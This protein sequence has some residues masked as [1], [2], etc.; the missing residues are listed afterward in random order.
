M[1]TRTGSVML[2]FCVTM[3]LCPSLA[4]ESVIK[5][6]KKLQPS[7]PPLY[8]SWNKGYSF[9][10]AE[11]VSTGGEIALCASP[12]GVCDFDYCIR[13]ASAISSDGYLRI[14]SPGCQLTPDVRLCIRS[15]NLLYSATVVGTIT[16]EFDDPDNNNNN[17]HREL[18]ALLIVGA[19]AA[20]GIACGGVVYFIVSHNR[21]AQSG[22]AILM[23]QT[24]ASAGVQFRPLNDGV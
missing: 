14:T 18:R 2:F 5:V 24:G 4:S 17:D 11:L 15:Q 7:T 20:F 22:G 12:G 10:S 3:L 16:V 23:T 1:T 8:K 6:N 19:I 9:K 13:C 21:R